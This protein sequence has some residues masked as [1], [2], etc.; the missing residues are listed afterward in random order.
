MK[1][2]LAVEHLQELVRIPTIS[3]VD[4]S[5]TE[6][7][8]FDRFAQTLRKLYP[9]CHSRLE[10]ETVLEHSLIFRW[11]GR[12]S[13]EPAVLMGHYDVVAATDEGWKRPPFAAELSGKGDDQLIWGRGTL[14]DKGSVAAILEA[15][16]A[17]LEEGLVPA[18]DIYLCFGHD[19]ETHGTGASAIVDLLE[20]RGVKPTLVLDEGGAIVDDV[21]DQ[22]DAPMAVVGVAE[23]GTATLRLTVDQSGGHASTPPKFPAAVRLAQAIVR[24]NS[25]PFPSRLT[26]TG[27]DLMRLLGEHAGGFTGYLLRNVSWT[28]PFLLPILVRK[29]DELAAMM[30]TTQAVTILEGG[31]AVNAMPERVSAV[32]NVRIAV[33]SSLNE[34]I[35]HV[36]R[37]INDK[38]VRISVDSPG[39]PSPVSGTTGLAWELLR[40][41]IEKT[42]PGTIVTPY[43]QNGATDSRHFT[44]ISGGVYRFTP[45]AMAREMRDTLHARNERM[46]VSSFL[47][48]IAFYRALIAS[49]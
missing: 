31:H 7:T 41:T 27:A 11:R 4:P 34:T 25:R 40:S 42:F 47:D 12:A 19:E 48:G 36:T 10:R 18:Q 23:K 21:F 26:D 15:V 28:K 20:S 30:R 38:R 43:V 32:I 44:R 17:Q 46:L 5:T 1:S 24:L 2:A 35:A 3:R 6:W 16:E 49:L 37:A 39:E 45:F 33:N 9:L 14:D 29:S 13:T 8:E 22:V